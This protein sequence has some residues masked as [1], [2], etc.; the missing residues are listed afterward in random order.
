MGFVDVNLAKFKHKRKY[1]ILKHYQSIS[2]KRQNETSERVEQQLIGRLTAVTR[3]ISLVT[4]LYVV[5]DRQW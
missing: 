5:K 2:L 3:H 4:E 1:F